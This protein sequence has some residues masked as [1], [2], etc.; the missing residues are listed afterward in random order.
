MFFDRYTIAILLDCVR[1]AVVLHSI[2][3]F[4]DLEGKRRIGW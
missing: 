3:I 2:V 4:D 1:L